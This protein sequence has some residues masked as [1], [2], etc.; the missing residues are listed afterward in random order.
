MRALQTCWMATKCMFHDECTRACVHVCTYVCMYACMYI[1][2]YMYVCMHACMDAH[3]HVCMS[4]GRDEMFLP[5][6]AQSFVRHLGARSP[7]CKVAARSNDAY[8]FAYAHA[9][10]ST[11]HQ[12]SWTNNVLQGSVSSSEI[13]IHGCAIHACVYS[14]SQ[15]LLHVLQWAT[16]RR[17]QA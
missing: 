2:V 12:L 13:R 6:K 1:Y 4:I 9:Q 16:R 11:W 17:Q 15:S 10:A 8:T 5:C 3:M 14:H 7:K